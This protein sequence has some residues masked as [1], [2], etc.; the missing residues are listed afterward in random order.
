[1]TADPAPDVSM[2]CPSCGYEIAAGS[3]HEMM[4]PVERW[5]LLDTETPVSPG[6]PLPL[7]KHD[8]PPEWERLSS[9]EPSGG[10]LGVAAP[11]APHR[12]RW[13]PRLSSLLRRWAAAHTP[14]PAAPGPP[15]DDDP[16]MTAAEVLDYW[17]SLPEQDQCHL[18]RW[19]DDAHAASGRRRGSL[20]ERLREEVQLHRLHHEPPP[21]SRERRQTPH[22][23]R[24]PAGAGVLPGSVASSG[25]RQM[26]G[27]VAVLSQR[28]SPGGGAVPPGRRS[29]A[30]HPPATQRTRPERSN[31]MTESFSIGPPADPAMWGPLELPL[32]AQWDCA[33]CDESLDLEVRSCGASPNSVEVVEAS[34]GSCNR[35]WSP[36]AAPAQITEARQVLLTRILEA[37]NAVSHAVG[38]VDALIDYWLAL[39][40]GHEQL[41]TSLT[42]P[43]G[44]DPGDR[45]MRERLS[46]R[47]PWT[48]A[49][50]QEGGLDEALDWWR[51]NGVGD[52][53]TFDF[54]NPDPTPAGRSRSGLGGLAD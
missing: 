2:D 52:P 13:L 20:H 24:R 17:H 38:R 11:P 14:V 4:C 48:A 5:Y 29:G 25:F 37:G 8:H 23:R 54:L 10:S 41:E 3:T 49:F 33:F 42:V 6:A 1:M 39:G 19:L 35:Q 32:H 21:P 30:P 16:A 7:P 45:F 50:I 47:C 53:G 31:T 15:A 9:E 18:A 26:G 46:M 34:C 51:S 12:G 22:R 44:P 43:I 28:H 36:A 40:L 27:G